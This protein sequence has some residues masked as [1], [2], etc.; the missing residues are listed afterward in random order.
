MIDSTFAVS[1]RHAAQDFAANA[2]IQPCEGP[3]P[4][5]ALEDRYSVT[6]EASR[7]A[8]RLIVASLASSS[9][10]SATGGE[11]AEL[12]LADLLIAYESDGKG[13]ARFT[14]PP[15]FETM[16]LGAA[17]IIAAQVAAGGASNDAIF[18]A[19]AFIWEMPGHWP[20]GV[21]VEPRMR[22]EY[23]GPELRV[24]GIV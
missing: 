21:M 5:L 10:C 20:D 24:S 18:A 17:N 1:V 7:A 6:P 15:R 8:A 11:G 13:S 3:A 2:W 19:E 12:Q 14:L 16:L 9:G 23:S 22:S 4:A